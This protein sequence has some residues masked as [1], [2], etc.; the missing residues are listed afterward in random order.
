MT[1]HPT[2]DEPKKIKLMPIPTCVNLIDNNQGRRVNMEFKPLKSI[3][4][5]KIQGI[6]QETFSTASPIVC[7][8]KLENGNEEKVHLGEVIDANIIT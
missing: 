6:I 3:E 8:I 4:T 1:D 2:P 7:V 5:K